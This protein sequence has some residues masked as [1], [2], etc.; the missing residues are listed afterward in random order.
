MGVWGV[1]CKEARPADHSSIHRVSGGGSEVT[2][3]APDKERARAIYGTVALTSHRASR[4]HLEGR[5]R[6]ARAL[7]VS[8]GDASCYQAGLQFCFY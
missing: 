5:K 2:L 1:C 7:R 8:R 4:S 6:S 3:R